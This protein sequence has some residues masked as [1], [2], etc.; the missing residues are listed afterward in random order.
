M[1]RFLLHQRHLPK[2]MAYPLRR[3]SLDAI[4]EVGAVNVIRSVTFHFWPGRPH[5]EVLFHGIGRRNPGAGTCDIH[6]NAVSRRE[7][8]SAE[9]LLLVEAVPMFLQW[10]TSATSAARAKPTDLFYWQAWIVGPKL[11]VTSG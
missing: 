5:F 7:L 10:L 9:R 11:K 4:F 3:C 1:R 8:E 6:I 2:G